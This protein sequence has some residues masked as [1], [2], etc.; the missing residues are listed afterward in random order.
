MNAEQKLQLVESDVKLAPNQRSIPLSLPPR[1]LFRILPHLVVPGTL[2]PPR[3]A[4]MTGILSLI[5]AVPFLREPAIAL[6]ASTKGT[7]LNLEV[8]E[9]L[10][11]DCAR[12]LLAAPDGLVLTVQ[13]KRVYEAMRRYK[14]IELNIDSTIELHVPWTPNKTRGV[15][16]RRIR[17]KKCLIKYVVHHVIAF[18]NNNG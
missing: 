13:E 16:D 2:Y 6:L 14:L 11:F 18:K 12:F 3:A 5:T 15:G 9:N 17:C 10:S 4:S 1:D 7:W 8:P